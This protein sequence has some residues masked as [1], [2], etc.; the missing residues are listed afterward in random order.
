MEKE[1]G[2]ELTK[3]IT[4]DVILLVKEAVTAYKNDGKFSTGE[5]LGMIDNVIPLLTDF[6]K[7]NAVIAEIKNLDTDEGKELVN[8]VL[9]LGI[10]ND[11]VELIVV[12]AV[13]FIE[14]VYL[15]YRTNLIP[16]INV[17]KK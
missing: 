6:A 5:M 16:I 1:L 9:S 4:K 7:F 12:N 10:V 3:K 11:K 8:F 15:L 14:G 2:I 13:E 17:F